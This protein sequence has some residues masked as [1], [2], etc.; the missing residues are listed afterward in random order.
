MLF[1]STSVLFVD[2]TECLVGTCNGNG[3]CVEEVGGGVVCVCDGGYT[4]EFCAEDIDYCDSNPC[5]NGGTCQE[6]QEGFNCVCDAAWT[7]NT[8]GIGEFP[9][10][11][12]CHTLA[13]GAASCLKTILTYTYIYV[14]LYMYVCICMCVVYLKLPIKECSHEMCAAKKFKTFA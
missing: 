13:S 3:D 5:E 10:L 2:I 6:Q 12:S 14:L 8:C 7:G 1:R 11:L 4:G 9:C